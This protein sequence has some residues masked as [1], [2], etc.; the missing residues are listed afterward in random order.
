MEKYYLSLKYL[1]CSGKNKAVMYKQATGQI[2]ASSEIHGQIS[3]TTSL[4]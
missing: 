3:G 4:S 2:Q 1:S